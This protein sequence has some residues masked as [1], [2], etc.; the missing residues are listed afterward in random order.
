MTLI[1]PL[2]VVLASTLATP[3]LAAHANPWMEEGDEVLMQYHEENLDQSEDTPLEDA[4]PGEQTSTAH[5]KLDLDAGQ[6][7]GKGLANGYAGGGARGG[8]N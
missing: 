3:L 1:S 7:D 6:D 2:A 8:R 5:G 4:M